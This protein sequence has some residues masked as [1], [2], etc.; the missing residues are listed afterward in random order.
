[1]VLHNAVPQGTMVPCGTAWCIKCS[2][3]VY[4]IFA[5][6]HTVYLIE[7]REYLGESLHQEGCVARQL[8]EA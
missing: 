5:F 7:M 2:I 6:A 3:V 8:R 4:Y 1:M